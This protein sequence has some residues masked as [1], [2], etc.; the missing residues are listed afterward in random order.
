MPVIS[1]NINSIQVHYV[2]KIPFVIRQNAESDLCL[3]VQGSGSEPQLEFDLNLIAFTPVLPF[4]PGT[5]SEVT[6]RNPMSYPVEFYSLEFDKQ[7]IEEEEVCKLRG[8]QYM[9]L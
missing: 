9:W 1:S 5:E 2:D 4:S 8:L 7:Y 3:T 6:V